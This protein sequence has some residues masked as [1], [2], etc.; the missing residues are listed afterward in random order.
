[1]AVISTQNRAIINYIWII[2][3]KTFYSGYII[4]P[5]YTYF[6]P[7]PFVLNISTAFTYLSLSCPV[8]CWTPIIWPYTWPDILFTSKIP[9]TFSDNAV[10][11]RKLG[12]LIY[13]SIPGL[14][15]FT[16]LTLKHYATQGQHPMR[17]GNYILNGLLHAN[18]QTIAF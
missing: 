3:S 2:N 4:Y 16:R 14:T 12:K 7:R 8:V 13:R 1:M 9:S 17:E 15:W 11:W 18:V 6:L 10:D 5:D